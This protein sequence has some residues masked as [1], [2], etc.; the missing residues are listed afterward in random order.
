M[1][2]SSLLGCDT[3]SGRILQTFWMK[4]LSQRSDPKRFF[5]FRMVEGG[6]QLGP[7][8]TS[9]TNW[10]IVPAPGDY[11]D[12]E[13]GGMMIDRRNQSKRRKPT[14]VLLCP[15]KIPHTARKRTRAA[16]VGS[17]LRHGQVEN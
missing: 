5:W 13:F 2:S 10:P 12:G 17:Q 16:A 3:Q 7:L 14:P 9:A 8:G 11:E 1:K 6:V 15:P 4:V